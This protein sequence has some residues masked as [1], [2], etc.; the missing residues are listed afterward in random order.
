MSIPHHYSAHVVNARSSHTDLWA[1]I[2]PGSINFVEKCLEVD[3]A[4][5]GY[6]SKDLCVTNEPEH[7]EAQHGEG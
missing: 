4:Q 7:G 5:D 2:R 1:D 6:P 3:Q